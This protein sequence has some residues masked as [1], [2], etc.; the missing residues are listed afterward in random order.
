[1][2]H[3]VVLIQSNATIYIIQRTSR[4]FDVHA[5]YVRQYSTATQVGRYTNAL[6]SVAV[7]HPNIILTCPDTS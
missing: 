2:K 6:S 5:F 3:Q 7:T 4:W 1:M